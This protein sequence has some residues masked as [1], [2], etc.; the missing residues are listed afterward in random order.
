MICTSTG[1]DLWA[2]AHT[3]IQYSRSLRLAAIQRPLNVDLL[4]IAIASI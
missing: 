3:T 1:C 2:S 4:G